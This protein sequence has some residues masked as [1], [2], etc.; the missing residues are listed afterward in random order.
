AGEE[1]AHLW[2]SNGKGDYTVDS[3]TKESRGTAVTL[4]LKEDA[5]E[6]TDPA[7]LRAV[8]KRHSDH[9]A[10]PIVLHD[11]GKD[12][13]I[14]A[15]SALWLRPKSEIMAEQYR[16]FYHHV[17]HAFDEPWL[18]LH[19][20]A[21]GTLEY[22]SLLFVPSTKPFDLF[23][24]E[25]KHRVKL[26]VKRVFITDDCQP[27]LPAYLRFLKG[28]VDSED[29]PL[30][31]SREMLQSNPMLARIRGQIVKR[32]LGEL[33][34][35]A[36]EAPEEYARFWENFGAVLKEGLYEDRDERDSLLA[37][38]RFRSI[39]AEGLVSLEDY[40]ARMKPGQE[41]I[42]TIAGDNLALLKKSP[43]LEGFRARG[44]EVLLLTDPVDEFWASALGKYKDWGLKSVTRGGA[45]LAK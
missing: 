42:Y 5:A 14:N 25:R 41:A 13:A 43:Q 23:D 28:I 11:E 12:E 17:G 4:H 18:T 38:A 37:L 1:T 16:E 44:V 30:N 3:G 34:K 29:L 26:Y 45:D 9:I 8:V 27:L 10:V 32:V 20:R 40:T 35:K 6:F 22:T 7:R 19:N 33:Q 15:A 36:K 39:A 21:E 31:I 2:V 24:P